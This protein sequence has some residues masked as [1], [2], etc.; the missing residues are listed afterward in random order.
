MIPDL[1][2]NIG[3]DLVRVSETAALAAARWAGSGNYVAAHRAASRAMSDALMGLE[4]QG[5]IVIGE[6]S[7]PGTPDCLCSA[8]LVGTGQGPELDVVVDPIDGTNLLIKGRPNAISVVGMAPRGSL[9]SPVPAVYMEKIVVDRQAAEALVPE[10]MDAPAAWTLALIARVK[11]KAVRDLTVIVLDRPRHDHLVAEIRAAGARI[12]LREE[13]DTEGALLVAS[14]DTGAD[15]LMGIG[16]AAQGVIA[17]CA[18]KALGGGMLARLAPQTHEEWAAVTQAGLDTRQVLTCDDLVHGQE[19]FF[20]ATGI[21]QSAL[22]PPTIFH[23]RHVETHSL[24]LRGATGT[25]RFI[26]AEHAE[27]L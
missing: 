1:S 13:G 22:L 15:V 21:T 5:H 4:I 25:R 7:H 9:W 6:E 19:I 23:S 18:V 11:K 8:S 20:A 14:L 17:A 24:L 3:L 16:G 27:H 10:C 12:L 26:K 2:R